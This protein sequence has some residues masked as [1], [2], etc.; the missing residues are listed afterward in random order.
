[1]IAASG[2]RRHGASAR[3][4]GGACVLLTLAAVACG[5]D[6]IDRRCEW[7]SDGTRSLRADAM[8]AED[9]AVRYADVTAGRRSGRRVGPIEYTRVRDA[10][11]A[12]VYAQVAAA[13]GASIDEVRAAAA[14]RPAAFDA[15]VIAAFAAVYLCVA[16]AIAGW[17]RA[18]FANSRAVAAVVTAVAAAATAFGG[19]LAGGIWSAAAEIARIGNDHLSFRGFRIPWHHHVPALFIGGV[20]LF[21]AASAVE[22]WQRHATTT[23]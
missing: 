13:H 17:I 2:P 8:R 1:M 16:V 6:R 9:V 15:G 19:V 23:T 3:L 21:F 20:A 14:E 12:T 7:Q 4:R 10:C 5:R 22:R 18:R 11:L